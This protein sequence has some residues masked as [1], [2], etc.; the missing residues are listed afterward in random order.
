[1]KK[2]ICKRNRSCLC[3]LQALEPDEQCPI[4]GGGEWPPRCVECGK[5]LAHKLKIVGVAIQQPGVLWFEM[6]PKRHHDVIRWAADHG[7]NIPVI[8][9]QGFILSD[10]T[11]VDRIEGARIAL[12]S[13]QITKLNWPPELYSEDLW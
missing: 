11:F 7:S 3:S 6:K 5:F 1:M 10:G 12:E 9:I 2:H 4:H 13:G 8:G